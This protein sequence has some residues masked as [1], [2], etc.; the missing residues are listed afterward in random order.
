MEFMT[1]AQELAAELA[2]EFGSE[3]MIFNAQMRRGDDWIT[4]ELYRNA[5]DPH[6]LHAVM[7]FDTGCNILLQTPKTVH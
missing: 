3:E 1:K 4:L 6:R 2:R 5:E 7:D